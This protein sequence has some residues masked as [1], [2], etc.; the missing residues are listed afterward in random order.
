MIRAYPLP[1]TSLVLRHAVVLNA[2]VISR[3]VAAGRA[4]AE[5]VR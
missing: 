2:E 1:V 3:I 5:M 4:A